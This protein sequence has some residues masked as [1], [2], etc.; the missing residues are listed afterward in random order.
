MVI[1]IKYEIREATKR[2][3]IAGGLT[4]PRARRRGAARR[5]F[6]LMAGLGGVRSRRARGAR[7]PGRAGVC[8][9]APTPRAT[10]APPSP[11]RPPPCP[12]TPSSTA[13]STATTRTS[14]GVRARRAE[15]GGAGEGEGRARRRAPRR[16]AAAAGR[17]PF[18]FFF[19]RAF[20]FESTL[21]RLRFLG[22]FSGCAAGGTRA[23]ELTPLG[24]EG[25]QK[26]ARA[27]ACGRRGRRA[28]AGARPFSARWLSC[29][30]R[31]AD[32]RERARAR[33]AA[34][35]P[36]DADPFRGGRSRL[37]P[38]APRPARAVDRDGALGVSCAG[39]PP[40]VAKMLPK[41]KLMKEVR[42]PP[43]PPPAARRALRRRPAPCRARTAIGGKEEERSARPSARARVPR[44][45]NAVA[46]RRGGRRSVCSRA[47]GSTTVR[48]LICAAAPT[49]PRDGRASRALGSH[50]PT[51]CARAD[52][53]DRPAFTSSPSRRRPPRVT[54]AAIHR[55]EPHIMLF[56]RPLNYGQQQQARAGRAA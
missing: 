10:Q 12:S 3:A 19:L 1:K 42:S 2:L 53:S 43:P 9:G 17:P 20:L 16:R 35:G 36:A 44:P 24:A 49:A 25:R 47:G 23:V 55:P 21:A 5:A 15:G 40:D 56:K 37:P 18:F 4:P 31:S 22:C 51:H 6:V 52:A 27:D 28:G 45:P 11:R 26:R 33:A 38:P 13:R 41:G 46:S 54:P 14:T 7:A 39:A 8:G 34:C 50:A 29:P 32:A 48:A 30:P